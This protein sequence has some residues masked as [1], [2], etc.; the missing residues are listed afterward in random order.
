MPKKKNY[1]KLE[2]CEKPCFGYGYCNRHYTRFK[3][4]GHP[5]PVGKKVVKAKGQICLLDDCKEPVEGRGMC[6]RHYRNLL[7]HNDPFYDSGY[8]GAGEPMAFILQTV[9]NPPPDRCVEWPFAK[10]PNG[11]GRTKEG[12]AHRICFALY[13]GENPPDKSACHGPC[14]NPGCINPHTAHGMYWGTAA[15]NANDKIRDGTLL[16]GEQIHGSK[17]NR[18]KVL[19]IRKDP[20]SH[21]AIA[22][23]YNIARATVGDIKNRR[24]WAWLKDD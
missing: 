21:S 13:T 17:L 2:G 18:A 19:K 3:K 7:K 6:R 9:K 16:K 4:Y 20:R 23:D 15:D 10:D 12:V 5:G 24:R 8:A 14:N 1:C 22:K 11:Y